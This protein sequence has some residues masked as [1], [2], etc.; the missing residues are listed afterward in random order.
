[1]RL[2]QQGGP[3]AQDPSPAK[4]ADDGTSLSCT[5][6]H[7]PFQGYL[8]LCNYVQMF[9]KV[10]LGEDILSRFIV[11]QLTKISYLLDITLV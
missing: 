6:V 5:Q 4:D 3:A 2:T 7:G 1:M 8:T 11:L 10:T 9:S